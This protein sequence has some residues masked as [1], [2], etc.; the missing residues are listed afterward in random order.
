MDIV[1][2]F[3]NILKIQFKNT[4]EDHSMKGQLNIYKSIN[5]INHTNDLK[6]ISTGTKSDCDKIQHSSLQKA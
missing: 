4:W 1:N 6:D 3:S 5:V 2:I